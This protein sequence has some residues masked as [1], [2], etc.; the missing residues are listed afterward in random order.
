M[1]V[2]GI[3]TL[4]AREREVL[5][6]LGS[7]R[8]SKQVARELGLTVETV[9]SYTKRIYAALDIHNRAEATVAAIE[10]GLVDAPIPNADDPAG[11]GDTI[12]APIR[13]VIG[14]QNEL[15]TLVERLAEQRLVSIVGIGG[16][17]KT[18]LAREAAR[19]HIAAS[20]DRGAFVSL[21]HVAD[22]VG[23]AIA[24]AEALGVHLRRGG[25]NVWGE[26]VSLAA[27]APR[28]LV[29]D[30]LE[31]L[32]DH[33]ER[34]VGLLEAMPSLRML[35]T[36]RQSLGV[37]EETVVRID[38]LS[39]PDDDLLS[40]EHHGAV[41]LFISELARLDSQRTLVPSDLRAVGD[42]CRRVGG[43]PLAVVLAAGWIDVLSLED[44]SAQLVESTGLLTSESAV[45]ERHRS[46]DALVDQS[47]ERRPLPEQRVLARMS[48]F[49][50]GFD[51]VA[52]EAVAGA[53]LQRLSSLIRGSLVRHDPTAERYDLHPLVRARAA[54]LLERQHQ[55]AATGIAHC[56]HYA[57]YVSSWAEAM[58][59]RPEPPGQRE[60]V[61]ALERERDNIRAAWLHAV[62]SGDA[63]SVLAMLHTLAIWLDHKSDLLECEVLLS[64]ALDS[65]VAE[66]LW[67]R[68]I[69]HREYIRFQSGS[70]DP[71]TCRV[72][73][74]LDAIEGAGTGWLEPAEIITAYLEVGVLG[75]P[76][77][78]F[79][80]VRRLTSPDADTPPFWRH[81]GQ[82]L[83]AFMHA[84][85]GDPEAA[86]ATHRRGMEDAIHAGDHSGA[87]VQMI[88]VAL[89]LV[90]A[91]RRDEI[92]EVLAE[93]EQ[94]L[95]LLPNE[96]TEA[97]LQLVGLILAVF[98]GEEVDTLEKRLEHAGL[99]RIMRENQHMAN[100]QNGV[101]S[102]AHGARGDRDAARLGREAQDEEVAAGFFG[103]SVLWAEL[104][105]A[106][107]A[108]IHGDVGEAR[109]HAEAGRSWE[110]GAGMVTS[111]VAV[112]LTLID[113]VA[114][115]Q[116]G[117]QDRSNVLIDEALSAPS[118]LNALLR[119][120]LGEIGLMDRAT[121]L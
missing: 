37:A 48:V 72:H 5:R 93:V 36:S 28:L 81:R 12:A 61:E 69:L 66:Q 78:A 102:L 85:M 84:A 21:E 9:R 63:A 110:Q 19:A 29:L 51:R 119:K 15:A 97:S 118:L 4:T 22:E 112:V 11:H 56:N 55:T 1:D 90:R 82:M 120:S 108:A 2:D 92:P 47:I 57:F 8:S 99:A 83:M 32:I 117:A 74:A 10:I 6:S 44:I 18:V 33:A 80:R 24:I 38:G 79:E 115:A 106:L 68:L 65:P 98:D 86:L 94:L 73:E 107:A 58:E 45:P 17:G 20:G 88:F 77:D 25:G 43:L 103:E 16:A 39:F 76:E 113:A 53:T 26:L 104:G 91:N 31:D 116:D 100:L 50:G 40:R 89:G 62:A 67:P 52:A 101:M 34:L 42:I 95:A 3:Q 87:Q 96:Q 70:V 13:A 60:A 46:L 14:R 27:D 114:A 7:G 64:A 109:S 121:T 59:G 49:D 35:T 23:L 71:A 41:E 30:N 75:R 111:E 54:A 105:V